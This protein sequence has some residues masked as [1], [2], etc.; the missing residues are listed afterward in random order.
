MICLQICNIKSAF[1]GVWGLSL[2]ENTHTMTYTAVHDQEITI[3]PSLIVSPHEPGIYSKSKA[4]L[5]S[6]LIEG[7]QRKPN[8]YKFIIQI[9]I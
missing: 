9:D 5:F 7:L 4:Y 6:G 3:K 2:R 8:K 1:I